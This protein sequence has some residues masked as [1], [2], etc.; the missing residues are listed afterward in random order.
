MDRELQDFIKLPEEFERAAD[1]TEANRL[2]EYYTSERYADDAGSSSFINRLY[3]ALK[4]FLPRGIQMQLRRAY[5]R[6]QARRKFPRWPVEP[7]LIE[8]LESLLRKIGSELGLATLPHL[9]FWP[10]GKQWALVLTH[11]VEGVGGVRNIRA[12]AE[13]EKRQGFRSSWNFVPERYPFDPR[14][15]EDLKADGF[16]IGVHGLHHDGL[17]F[18]SLQTFRQRLPEIHRYASRWSAGG[19]RSPATHRNYE[20]MHELNF[21]YD[22]SFP[23]TDVFEP[24]PGGCCWIFPFFVRTLLEIPITL[25]QDHTLLEILKKRDFALWHEK[26]R[27]IKSKS[28]LALLILHPDYILSAERLSFYEDFLKTMKDEVGLWSALP[29]EV[30]VWWRKRHASHLVAKNGRYEIVGP[31]E[32]E[33]YVALR[34]LL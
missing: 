17:L 1:W 24:N 30:A 29:S 15:L 20:W 23:D 8:I 12:V 2:F 5:S 13:V 34:P 22:S 25:P 27:W 4:P 28:G 10:K 18:Q 21:Q 11:D 16:E 19:F 14:I 9:G 7:V 33:G 26:V 6:V 3:Y 32:G 31:A